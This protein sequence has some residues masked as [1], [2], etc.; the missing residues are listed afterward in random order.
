MLEAHCPRCFLPESE[1]D[2]CVNKSFGPQFQCPDPVA[3][4]PTKA[5][6]ISCGPCGKRLIV[7]LSDI[8][9][10]KLSLGRNC[11]SD[12]CSAQLL[13]EAPE[14]V[15]PAPAHAQDASRQRKAR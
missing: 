8:M 15:P 11:A 3:S 14:P 9:R 1:T 2:T 4:D 12:Q 7:P 5:A 13:F 6:H 10:G